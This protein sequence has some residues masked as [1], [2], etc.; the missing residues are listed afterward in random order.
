MQNITV[1]RYSNPKS[2]GWA[3]YIQPDDRSWIA[4]IGLDGRPL[5]FLNRDPRTGRI[6]SDDPAEAAAELAAPPAV[7][8]FTGTICGGPDETATPAGDVVIPLGV[9]GNGGQDVKG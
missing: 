5:F 7:G 3:G 6:L 2:H 9:S 4:F 8:N 1:S